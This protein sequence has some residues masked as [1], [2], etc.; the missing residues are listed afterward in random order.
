MLATEATREAVNSAEF[1]EEVRRATGW[2]VEM[3]GKEDEGRVGALGVVSS[4]RGVRGLVM[5]LGGGSTQLTWVD[6]GSGGVGRSVSLPFGAAA[7]LRRLT[8]AQEE[9]AVA[10]QALEGDVA[11]KLAAAYASLGAP[12]PAAGGDDAAITLYLSG[13]GFRGWGYVLMDQHPVQPYPIPIINGFGVSGQVFAG[14]VGAVAQHA[15]DAAAAEDAIFRVSDRRTGQ[16]PAVA[17]LI[18]ALRAAVPRIGTVRFCQGGVRE[19]ALYDGLPAQIQAQAPLDAATRE[20]APRSAAHIAAL[21]GAALPTPA[22]ADVAPPRLVAQTLVALANML[23]LHGAQTKETRAAA[24][25]RSTTTGALA[26]THGLL[27]EE[28]ALLALLLCERWGGEADVP[29]TDADFL[30]R[31]RRLVG[32]ALDWW[33]RYLGAVARLVG[34]VYPAGVVD[35]AASRLRLAARVGKG[36]VLEVAFLG[37]GA[38][39]AAGDC[40]KALRAVEKVGKKK[41]WV[42]GREGWGLKV[43]V[44]VVGV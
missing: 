23:Y 26:A 2:V 31:L 19:G 5:D 36:V 33:A 11:G 41:N 42:G 37:D 39:A 13:G 14:R 12:P 38:A 25:L 40:D 9:G 1:R 16:I 34:D 15:Q 27:H 44:D 8:A 43:E 3:L 20:H 10:T 30:A 35:E 7:L 17:F 21:L 4:L 32:P 24:A 22:G 28:R 6:G 18:G 29:A